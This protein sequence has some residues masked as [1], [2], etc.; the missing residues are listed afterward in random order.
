[1][2]SFFGRKVNSDIVLLS[3]PNFILKSTVGIYLFASVT[4][5]I[6]A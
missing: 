5:I 4:D 2:K 1:M 6:K 3:H